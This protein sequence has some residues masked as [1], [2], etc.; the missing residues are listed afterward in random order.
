MIRIAGCK[1]EPS[2]APQLV[3]YPLPKCGPRDF[4]ASGW[5][6]LCTSSHMIHRLIFDIHTGTTVRFGSLVLCAETVGIQLSGACGCGTCVYE[7]GSQGTKQTKQHCFASSTVLFH[8]TSS[9]RGH[10]LRYVGEYG[11]RPLK[12]CRAFGGEG[13]VGAGRGTREWSGLGSDQDIDKEVGKK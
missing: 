10:V 2:M 9:N 13:F 4:G 3:F 11:L 12:E 6:M 5:Y 8:L 7:H 1:K